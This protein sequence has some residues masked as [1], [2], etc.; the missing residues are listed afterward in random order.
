MGPSNSQDQIL[1][2]AG[3][4]LSPSSDEFERLELVYDANVCFHLSVNS[5][6]FFFLLCEGTGAGCYYI[7]AMLS[8]V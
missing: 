3:L 7:N 2:L 1:F 5:V 4:A 8:F 6:M